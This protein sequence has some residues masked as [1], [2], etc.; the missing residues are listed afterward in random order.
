MDMCHDKRIFIF[1]GQLARA[2]ARDTQNGTAMMTT[3]RSRTTVRTLTI[4][5]PTDCDYY[6][7]VPLD[8]NEFATKLGRVH[9]NEGLRR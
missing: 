9:A 3:S 2:P 1:I 5:G 6:G 4:A 8:L 7:G